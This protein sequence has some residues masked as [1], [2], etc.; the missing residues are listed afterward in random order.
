LLILITRSGSAHVPTCCVLSVT[1]DLYRCVRCA[2][3]LIRTWV[4]CHCLVFSSSPASRHGYAYPLLLRSRP[5]SRC[6]CSCGPVQVPF[7]SPLSCGA[8]A[9]QAGRLLPSHYR[10]RALSRWRP[11]FAMATR[12]YYSFCSPRSSHFTLVL[13]SGL[14]GSECSRSH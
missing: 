2:G 12:G 7:L 11:F 6:V 8:D 1:F 5:N 3:R 14:V 13:V 9:L 10:V 4:L